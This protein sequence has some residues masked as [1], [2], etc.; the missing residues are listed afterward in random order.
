MNY[1][2]FVGIMFEY[3]MHT[4]F[5]RYYMV[6]HL[7]ITIQLDQK[8]L[9]A[10]ETKFWRKL[11][12]KWRTSTNIF[13]LFYHYLLGVV[14]QKTWK[15]SN[16]QILYVLLVEDNKVYKKRSTA[17]FRKWHLI[18]WNYERLNWLIDNSDEEPM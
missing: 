6:Y 2:K 17:S 15:W 4:V 12:S 18:E 9:R 14:L 11:F 16:L 13:C 10:I 7:R 1:K 8:S 3:K 5:L